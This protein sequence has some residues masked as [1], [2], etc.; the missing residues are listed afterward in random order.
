MSATA[1]S[2]LPI[3]VL[4]KSCKQNYRDNILHDNLQSK[5]HLHL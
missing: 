5:P 2:H 1:A 3:V 4:A